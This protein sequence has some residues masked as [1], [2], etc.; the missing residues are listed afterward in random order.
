MEQSGVMWFFGNYLKNVKL[1]MGFSGSYTKNNGDMCS[2]K[3]ASAL[4]EFLAR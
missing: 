3:K 1:C 4:S 2:F